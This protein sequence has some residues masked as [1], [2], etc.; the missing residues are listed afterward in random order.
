MPIYCIAVAGFIGGL[1]ILTGNCRRKLR[2]FIDIDDN[3]TF[4]HLVLNIYIV[5]ESRIGYLRV[6]T[7]MYMYILHIHVHVHLQLFVD[8]HV[9]VQ[10]MTE[11]VDAHMKM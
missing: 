10:Y 2:A 8:V 1:I 7:Y 4:I 6:H 11:N 5:F 9:H 3:K